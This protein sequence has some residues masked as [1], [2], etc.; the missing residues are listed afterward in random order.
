[1]NHGSE[2]KSSQPKLVKTPSFGIDFSNKKTLELREKDQMH[3]HA[4]PTHTLQRWREQNQINSNNNAVPLSNHTPITKKV[5]TL[6]LTW[7]HSSAV[8]GE[9]QQMGDNTQEAEEEDKEEAEGQDEEGE[10]EEDGEEEDEEDQEVVEEEEG[11]GD[12]VPK[13]ELM[14]ERV[15]EEEDVEEKEGVLSDDDSE[16]QDVEGSVGTGEGGG[17]SG[18]LSEQEV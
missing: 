5:P 8:R 14:K 15:E 17:V 4:P 18:Y 1:M 16:G 12:V 13:K 6:D 7:S 9:R 3:K 11:R 2:Q 10:G